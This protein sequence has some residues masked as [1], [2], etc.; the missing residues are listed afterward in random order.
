MDGS[1]IPV[2]QLAIGMIVVAFL[3]MPGRAKDD[4]GVPMTTGQK[5]RR[6]VAIART[7]AI[8]VAMICSVFWPGAGAPLGFLLAL[9]LQLVLFRSRRGAIERVEILDLILLSLGASAFL[10]LHLALQ[11]TDAVGSLSDTIGKLV[12]ALAK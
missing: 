3:A 12:D 7:A 1:W 8:G 11:L 10:T 2:A 5:V 6:V 4:V 9:A